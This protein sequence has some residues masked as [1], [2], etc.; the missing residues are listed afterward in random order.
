MSATSGF[1]WTSPDGAIEVSTHRSGIVELGFDQDGD[2][3]TWNWQSLTPVD[4]RELGRQI[5]R[6]AFEL[7]P[8]A[9][10]FDI[11]VFAAEL[12]AAGRARENLS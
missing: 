8:L 6:A 4:A 12:D 11:R 3:L 9:V 2:R 7:D 1:S 5:L 10:A